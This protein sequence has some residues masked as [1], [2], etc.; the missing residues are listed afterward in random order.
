MVLVFENSQHA[1]ERN[2][3]AVAHRRTHVH[4]ETEF[5]SMTEK[6]PKVRLFSWFTR[7]SRNFP[8]S[9]ALSKHAQI[10]TGDVLL[11]LFFATCASNDSVLDTQGSFLKLSCV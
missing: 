2:Y 10:W 7:V 4:K 11:W 1:M 8:H 9:V 3:G 6:V 5:N